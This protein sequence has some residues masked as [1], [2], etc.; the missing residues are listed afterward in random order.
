MRLEKVEKGYE[1]KGFKLGEIVKYK[2]L[3]CEIV[4]FTFGTNV[5][6]LG[7]YH[8]SFDEATDY[9]SSVDIDENGVYFKNEK[10]RKWVKIDEITKI[11]ENKMIEVVAGIDKEYINGDWKIVHEYGESYESEDNYSVI[12]IHARNHGGNYEYQTELCYDSSGD[13]VYSIKQVTQLLSGIGFKL[14]QPED[15]LVDVEIDGKK[16]KL[17]IE[18]AKELKILK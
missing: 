4:A 12:E 8:E 13:G 2:G 10:K 11:E 16:Y 3:E 18:K 6:F 1:Y 9:I 14:V 5:Y 7:I 17:D 15:K